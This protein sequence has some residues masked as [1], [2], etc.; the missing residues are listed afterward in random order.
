MDASQ[1]FT[2][3]ELL[4]EIKHLVESKFTLV[5][6]EGEI[7]N[8]S[9]AASGHYYFS[10][11][12][13]DALLTGALF[14]MDALRNPLV[15][16]LKDGDKVLI[17]GQVNLYPKRGQI[18]IIAKRVLPAGEGQLK[19]QL[20]ILKT[21][22]AGEGLFDLERK[23]PIPRYPKKV[24][25]ITAIDSA[26]MNDF[27]KIIKRREVGFSVSIYGALVQGEKAPDSIIKGLTTFERYNDQNPSDKFDVVVLLRGGGSL[28]D[29]W[30][31]NNEALARKIFQSP[32]PIISAVGHEVDFSISDYVADKR[33][34]T[35][36][37]AAE[38]LTEYFYGFKENLNR[39]YSLMSIN[40]RSVLKQ[41]QINL[42]RNSPQHFINQLISY[43]QV[44]RKRLE[45]L[46]II[47]HAD[48]L[49]GLIDLEFNLDEK[50]LRLISGL[51][52][53]S[54]NLQRKMMEL[55]RLLKAFNPDNILQKGYTYVK[56]TSGRVISRTD[57]FDRLQKEEQLIVKFHD[58]ERLVQKN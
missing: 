41:K 51:N 16:R 50:H 40:M 56:T 19:L 8:L 35:P 12:D 3:S 27:L 30:A 22:L 28:E 47:K 39:L 37:A 33:C 7:T 57:L 55:D 20:E 23:R 43:S 49:L 58:G 5:H 24:G 53:F 4:L 45:Q 29:L 42:E 31:F 52:Q 44:Q 46:S 18:Q 9:R 1:V 48:K 26:A 34:E 17:I 54:Q 25:V 32:F 13:S 15:S 21:K 11:S 6:V 14:K 36:S 2:V 10:L 38:V